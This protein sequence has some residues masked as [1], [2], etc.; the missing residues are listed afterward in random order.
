MGPRGATARA[1]REQEEQRALVEKRELL[2]VNCA[3][4]SGWSNH[5]Q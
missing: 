4:R 1:D 2:L 3:L 5:F